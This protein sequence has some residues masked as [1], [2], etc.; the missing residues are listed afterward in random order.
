MNHAGN[1]T[2]LPI[3]VSSRHGE[4]RFGTAK[5]PSM[6]SISDSGDLTVR[7]EAVDA[8]LADGTLRPPTFMKIDVEGAEYEVLTGSAD[9]LRRYAPTIFLSTHGFV[10]QEK[11]WDLLSQSGYQLKLLR[12]GTADGNYLVLAIR[13][14]GVSA[15]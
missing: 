13:K 3:A 7:T 15:D 2:I 10:Q 4:V 11:C 12:D 1:V 6:G 8:L 14:S 5:S 9:T